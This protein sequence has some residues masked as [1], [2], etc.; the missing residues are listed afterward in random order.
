MLSGKQFD[1]TAE[2]ACLRLNLYK[3]LYQHGNS[4][5]EIDTNP[6]TLFQLR[7]PIDMGKKPGRI[8][9][10]FSQGGGEGWPFG[11]NSHKIPFRTHWLSTLRSYLHLWK[12]VLQLIGKVNIHIVGISSIFQKMPIYQ[13]S[14]SIFH[15]KSM[16]KVLNLL[17]KMI[18]LP[19]MSL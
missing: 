13:Q 16:K 17:K 5:F 12:P 15:R 2:K 1:Y 10:T 6:I 19:K 18:F 11:K 4:C 8:R 7:C 3:K 9:P 14:I